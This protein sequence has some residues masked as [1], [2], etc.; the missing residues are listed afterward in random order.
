MI[1]TNI[2]ALINNTP[3]AIM[4]TIA[5][6]IKE[7]RLEKKLT[8][9]SLASRADMSIASY[10]RF[11]TS[12]EISFRSLIMLAIALN[13]TED[14]ESLFT[15]KSYDNINELIEGKNIKKRQRGLK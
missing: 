2:L 10:R 4:T 14:F 1:D 12:G 9:R 11:E 3:D 15:S 13:M 7:R 6:R 5:Q 8:Q